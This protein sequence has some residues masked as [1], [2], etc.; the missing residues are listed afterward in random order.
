MPVVQSPS[1]AQPRPSAHLLHV[2]PPQSTSVSSPFF[3]PSL[4]L[5]S[6]QRPSLQ[7]K[8]RQSS[9]KR[10]SPP[11]G[12]RAG[13]HVSP[14]SMSDS[15]PLRTPSSHLGA[16]QMPLAHTPLE[17]SRGTTQVCPVTHG[18]QSPPQSTSLSP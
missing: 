15:L 6:L 14:Q 9:L 16:A 2:E 17:Q 12:Q 13:E 7:T 18:V 1:T 10:H 4:H 5:A 8:L 11:E 3:R